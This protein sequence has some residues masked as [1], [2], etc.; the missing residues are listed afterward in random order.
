MESKSIDNQ[1]QKK[2]ITEIMQADEKDGL[3][4]ISK[5]ELTEKDQKLFFDAVINPPNPN[6]NLLKSAKNYEESV[7]N[8]HTL[9]AVEWLIKNL[10]ERFKNA[11]INTCTKEI[12][13]AKAMEMEKIIR[14]YEVGWKNGSLKKA[15]SFG[16]DYYNNINK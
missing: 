11:L 4:D 6:K 15:P 7:T 9:T 5:M 2:L 16:I 3:Y 10:P 8:N 1:Q 13:H 14:A 12:E